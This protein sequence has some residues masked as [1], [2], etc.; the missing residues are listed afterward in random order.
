[1]MQI[2]IRETQRVLSKLDREDLEL[3]S[4]ICYY[5]LNHLTSVVSSKVEISVLRSPAPPELTLDDVYRASK[6]SEYVATE[7]ARLVAEGN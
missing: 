6:V 1:M 7:V 2:P 4:L 3:F 5:S